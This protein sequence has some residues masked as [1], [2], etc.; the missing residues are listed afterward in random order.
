MGGGRG[1]HCWSPARTSSW[2]RC[3]SMRAAWACARLCWKKAWAWGE[4]RGEG[5]SA[6]GQTPARALASRARPEI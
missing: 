1:T 5:G 3:F 2:R 4:R 6:P